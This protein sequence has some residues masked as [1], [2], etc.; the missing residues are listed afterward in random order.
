MFTLLLAASVAAPNPARHEK[1]TAAWQ[2]VML[3]RSDAPVTAARP[4][5]PPPP[6]LSGTEFPALKEVDGFVVLRNQGRDAKVSRSDIMTPK[7]AVI[8]YSQQIAAQPQTTTY[9]TRRAKAYELLSDWDS[10]IK[11]YDEA[12]KLSPQQSAYWNNRA[13]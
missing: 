1:P 8:F 9:Y 12:L 11:D 5:D 7:E 3:K 2:T 6:T 4:G 10:A 13:N